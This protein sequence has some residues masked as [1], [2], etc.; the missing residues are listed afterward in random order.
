MLFIVTALLLALGH[1]AI[2][3]LRIDGLVAATLTAFNPDGSVNIAAIETQAAW[4]EATGV[5]WI[6]ACG[7]T[8]ES[9][10]LNTTERIQI[11]EEWLRVAPAHNIQVIVH[12]GDES[13]ETARFLARHAQAHGA[14]AIGAMSTVFFGPANSHALAT[15]MGAIASAAP[16]LPFYYYHIPSQTHVA[17]SDGM[18]GLALAMEEVGVPTFVGVKY[19]G[20]YTYPGFMDATRLSAYKNGKYEVFSGRDEMMVE[21]LAVGTTGFVGSQYN[22][23]GDLYNAIRAAF[24]NGDLATARALQLIAND[25]IERWGA[26][27]SAGVNG[28]KNV[29]NVVPQGINVGDARLPNMPMSTADRTALT[30]SVQ[31]WCTGTQVKGWPA[32]AKLC[33]GF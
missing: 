11:T 21:A 2:S 23:V 31:A 17:F 29:F 9:L 1:A 22:M 20:L 10:K 18:Y 13:V 6:F 8:G 14:A 24:K 25:F 30:A 28:F 33:K 19:T 7:T 4:L 16:N 12:V 27:V 15:T 3:P 32:N 26:A 5:H